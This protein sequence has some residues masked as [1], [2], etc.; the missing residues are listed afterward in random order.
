MPTGCARN[1][2]RSSAS[3]RTSW[4]SGRP[5]AG[6]QTGNQDT[7]P[8]RDLLAKYK[9]TLFRRY[10]AGKL[11]GRL[12][13]LTKAEAWATA[14]VE[15]ISRRTMSAAE[16]QMREDRAKNRVRDDG[17]DRNLDRDIPNV[18]FYVLQKGL[19][20]LW[21]MVREPLPT[22]EPVLRHLHRRAVRHGNAHPAD[23]RNREKRTTKSRGRLTNS[24][25]GLCPAWRNSLLKKTRSKWRGRFTARYS[26]SARPD[27]I[28]SRTSCRHGCASGLE[29]T[30]D[31]ATFAKIWTEMV[32]YAM[33]LPAWQPSAH[34][35]WSRAES[36]A[37]DLVGMHDDSATVLGQAKHIAV[38]QAMAPVFERWALAWLN[39]ASAAGWFSHFLTT[40]SGALLLV[41]GIKELAKVVGSFEDRDWHQ[42][43]LGGIFTDALAACWKHKQNEIEQQPELQKAFLKILTELC[44]RQVPEAL[45][46]RNKVSEALGSQGQSSPASIL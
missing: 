44:A 18:D 42:Q 25:S 21:A 8:N 1:S 14:L 19:G 16:R 12:L 39:H 13:P 38:V 22:D 9:A 37:V 40:E 36:L 43:G 30:A 29:M 6:E 34:G 41:M 5:F 3:W 11:K 27:G 7:R 15:R 20:F 23:A 24:T 26:I 45:H 17:R 32:D 28:G 4:C 33:A 10:T 35:Y 31:P 2:G 46:L